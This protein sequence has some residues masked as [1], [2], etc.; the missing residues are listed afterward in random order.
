MTASAHDGA[1][2]AELA[3]DASLM[4]SAPDSSLLQSSAVEVTGLNAWFGSHHVLTDIDMTARER[5][6]TAMIGPSG[7][8]KSTLIR[9][10]NRMHEE[11][12]GA[13]VTG[14]VRFKG[15]DMYAAHTDPV[16]IRRKVGMVFQRPTPF[17]TMSVMDNAVAGLKLGSK[18]GKSAM[19]A[20]GEDALRRAGLWDEVKD[21]LGHPGGMLSGGQQQRLCIARALAIEPEVLLMDEPASALDPSSTLRIEELI[22]KLKTEFAVIIVTHN[23]QQAARIADS[24]I[25]MLDG[26]VVET[27]PTDVIFNH[28]ADQ[29]TSDYVNGRFG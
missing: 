25:F 22:E 19:K 28:P 7:C 20:K 9:C 2:S 17:P 14:A 27:G 16:D 23:M 12:R 8:G 1:S 18:L 3:P 24:T 11:V 10:L 5:S 4:Q 15:A 29:R 6:V 13:K 26:H 21:R